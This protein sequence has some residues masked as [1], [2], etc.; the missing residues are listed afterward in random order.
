MAKSAEDYKKDIAERYIQ[1][2]KEELWFFNKLMILP[3]TN[4]MKDIL[5][6]DKK[7]NVDNIQDIEDLWFRRNVL[8]IKIFDKQLF[9]NLVNKILNFLKEKQEKI[10]K[11]ETEWRLDELLNLVVNWK[12]DNL[13]ERIDKPEE[14]KDDRP[15]EKKDDKPEEKKDDK[16]EEKKD[17]KPEEKKD[18]KP[19]EKKDDKPANEKKI[20]L[21]NLKWKYSLSHEDF[22]NYFEGESFGQRNVGDCWFLAAI[23]SLVSFWD[24]EKLIR[25]SVTKN[26]N[27][28]KIKLPLWSNSGKEYF[29]SFSEL[30][31]KQS[32]IHWENFV[33][34][35]WKQGIEALV[36]A[37]LRH[38][39]TDS[40]NESDTDFLNLNGWNTGLTFNSLLYFPWMKTYYA[41]RTISEAE[42]KK[43]I[44]WTKDTQFVSQIYSALEDFDSKNDMITLWVYQVDE[45][46][47]DRKNQSADN[48]NQL[49]H[50]SKSNHEISVEAV[51]KDRWNLIITVSNPWDSGRKYDISFNN[52]IKS[53]AS[54]TLCTKKERKWLKES[55]KSYWKWERRHAASN[56]ISMDKVRNVN[57]IIEITWK[58]NEELRKARGDII[59][60]NI[61]INKI[62]VTSYGRSTQVEQKNGNIIIGTGNEKLSIP[63]TEISNVFYKSQ[64]DMEKNDAYRLHL[65]WAKIA[66]MIHFIEKNYDKNDDLYL[67]SD[68]ILQYDRTW[69][70]NTD[71]IKDRWKLWINKDKTKIEFTKYLEKLW[72]KCEIN[73]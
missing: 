6:S 20:S 12:L 39:S 55:T 67:N 25:S 11:A 32:W 72:Y 31:K 29:I 9:G 15:E 68:W 48:Y 44:Q 60:E 46:N 40:N 57:Q 45:A 34:V 4:K 18:D 13:E 22:V 66:N 56:K 1:D 27:G 73:I 5:K 23:D 64:S 38:T 58:E 33:L 65:Y 21:D 51:K 47:N 71:I 19:E 62:T 69:P 3:I 26:K 70:R 42:Q 49:G 30:K 28:F 41:Q 63:E 53:C 10:I 61:D 37:Y 17:D 50:Y 7:I 2:F 8:G 59:V 36:R 52:L 16:P 14:K 54:F 43:D 24:Y 35:E